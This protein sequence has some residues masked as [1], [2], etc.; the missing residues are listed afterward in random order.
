MTPR[1]D[2][3][4]HFLKRVRGR[5]LDHVPPHAADALADRV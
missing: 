5:Y 4:T 3:V 2:L 1:N